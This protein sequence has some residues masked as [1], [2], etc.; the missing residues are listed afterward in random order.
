M[1]TISSAVDD[2]MLTRLLT[3]GEDSSGSYDAEISQTILTEFARFAEH[4]IAP[5]NPLA[6]QK[7]CSHTLQGVEL[8]DEFKTIYTHLA[9]AGWQGLSAPENFGGMDLDKITA[10]GVSELFSAS[11]HAL[12]MVCNLVPGAIA[13]LKQFGS[14][15]QQSRLIPPLADGSWLST[16]CL[17]EP[18]AGSDLSRIKSMA[19]KTDD[20]WTLSGE[21]IF[22]SG[23]D[24]NISTSILH[25]VLAR[26]ES[27]EKGIKGLSLFACP[28]HLG[29][30]LNNVSVL[31]VEDKLGI[32]ASP[33]CHM[34]FDSAKAELI[35]KQGE[36]LMAMFTLMNHARLD[37]ALQG[38]AH[39][40]Q[41]WRLSNNYAS[42][43][44]QG[45]KK[46]KT[47]AMLTDHPDVARMLNEQRALTLGGRAICY[48]TFAIIE[49][50]DS[51]DLVEFLTPLCKVFCSEAGIRAADLGIQIMGGYGYLKEYQIEQHWR[52]ARITSIYEGAN[53]VHGKM[54]VTRN[55]QLANGRAADQFEQLIEKLADGDAEVSRWRLLWNNARAEVEKAEQP[56]EFGHDF[57]Q[58]SAR[59]LFEAIWH[60]LS[61]D[62]K[63]AALFTSELRNTVRKMPWAIRPEWIGPVGIELSK[64]VS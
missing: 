6:D 32:N 34:H 38:I 26:T 37:V 35:G 27:A 16:M 64:E 42:E 46:D 22:I 2:M 14:D 31:R 7:G 41:A 53:G 11:C 55:L 59:L 23:G 44:E 50:G 57:T 4:E 61:A 29:D 48:Q 21:K 58:F 13:I 43:R 36:G 20:H 63:G 8:P 62:P 39:A 17:S 54:M 45:R 18:S 15:E 5:L 24:Q 51:P 56:E 3:T 33:T 9:E 19:T 28:K 10:A 40:Q 25:F 12:Q 30:E 49:D 60:H 52:D 1:I 47:P